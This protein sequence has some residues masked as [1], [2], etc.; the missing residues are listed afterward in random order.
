MLYHN[1]LQ[2]PVD[3]AMLFLNPVNTLIIHL[4]YVGKRVIRF[5]I[6]QRYFIRF[7]FLELDVWIELSRKSRFV[8]VDNNLK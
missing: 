4:V 1:Y 8:V 5:Q 7:V 6:N 2:V 3:G